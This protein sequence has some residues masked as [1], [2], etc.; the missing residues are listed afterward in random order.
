ML[1][2]DYN[3]LILTDLNRNLET[4]I[5]QMKF[6]SIISAVPLE[7][8]K[9]IK[10]ISEEDKLSFTRLNNK[11]YIKINNNL[12]SILKCNNKHIYLTLLTN[13]IKPPTA[14]ET[15]INI[16]PFL[17]KENWN[18]IYRRTF[19][20][21]KEPYLQS[22]QF[23]IINRILNNNENLY[24][25]KISQNSECCVCGE[26]DS[27]EHHLYY[28][29]DSKLFWKKLK[30]WMLINLEFGFE[31][32]VCEILFGV[33]TDNYVDTRLLNFLILIGKWFI[34]KR[35]TKQTSI[36]FIEYL[37]ILKDKVNTMIYI[38]TKEGLE[39]EPWLNT[40]QDVL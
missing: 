2:D 19:E 16:F 34:N 14:T 13:D 10:N 28:C 20:I 36:Y 31:L 1:D 12:Q 22:F 4:N 33:P 8:K 21:T 9:Q 24:N 26:I 35:R 15:W 11:P 38:P 30:N 40:L 6:N 39:V 37:S 29:K 7:W 23:K 25:W 17:E 5:S 27:I 3:F 18:A 32:T